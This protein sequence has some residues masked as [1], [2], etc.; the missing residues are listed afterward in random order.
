MSRERG[1][2]WRILRW[3]VDNPPKQTERLSLTCE[4]CGTEAWCPSGPMPG[5][6]IIAIVGMGVMFDPPNYIPPNQFLPLVIQC[7]YCRT[8]FGGRNSENQGCQQK[9]A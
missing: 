8:M 1:K 4:R 3:G 6:R 7:R 9:A 5:G 2:T